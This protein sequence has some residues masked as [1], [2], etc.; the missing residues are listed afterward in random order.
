MDIA[1]GLIRGELEFTESLLDIIYKCNLC[2]ACDIMCKRSR[3]LEPLLM[4]KA[5]RAKCVEEGQ[6]IP[7]HM[8]LIDSLKREDNV[9]GEP[10]SKRG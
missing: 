7:E 2:G 3:E 6:I 9:F 4:F 5:L 1:L 8:L 10:K